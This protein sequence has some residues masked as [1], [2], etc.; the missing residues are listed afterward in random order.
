MVKYNIFLYLQVR[1]SADLVEQLKD[2]EQVFDFHIEI[3]Q[4]IV[5]QY[6]GQCLSEHQDVLEEDGGAQRRPPVG[7]RTLEHSRCGTLTVITHISILWNVIHP[8]CKSA[9]MDLKSPE[10]DKVT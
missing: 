7:C 2:L 8:S 4:E 6:E 3:R 9:V 10:K 5:F 1:S